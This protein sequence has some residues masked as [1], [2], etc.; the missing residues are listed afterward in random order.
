MKK[1][2]K[3]SAILIIQPNN[4]TVNTKTIGKRTIK[5]IIPKI[6][7]KVCSR[8]KNNEIPK[9]KKRDTMDR[10]KDIRMCNI[11]NLLYKVGVK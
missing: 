8:F 7:L 4:I 11:W 10:T 9:A 3:V 2:N 1:A 6:W 5:A